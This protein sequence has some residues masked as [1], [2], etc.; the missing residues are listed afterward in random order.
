M[1]EIEVKSLATFYERLADFFYDIGNFI[2][3]IIKIL[4]GMRTCAKRK[5]AASGRARRENVPRHILYF[6]VS[7]YLKKGEI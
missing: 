2:P 5:C 1:V 4:R 7:I 3:Y 6:P